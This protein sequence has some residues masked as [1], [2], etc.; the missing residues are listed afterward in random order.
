MSALQDPEITYSRDGTYSDELDDA[1][2]PIGVCFYVDP[3]N[4]NNRLMM[5]LESVSY[6]GYTMPWG[7]GTGGNNNTNGSGQIN[8]LLWFTTGYIIGRM[9]L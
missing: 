5:A 7:L 1:K 8:W 9:S 6:S 3:K 2:V 4:A